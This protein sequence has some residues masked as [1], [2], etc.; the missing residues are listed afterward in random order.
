MGV[1]RE[2]REIIGRGTWIDKVA[3][4]VIEREKEL[5][6]PLDMIVTESGLGAPGIPH[7]GSLADRGLSLL[8][9]GDGRER[10]L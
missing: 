8:R 2:S 7:I 6:R 4:E 3:R 1:S 9:D 10:L 5:G